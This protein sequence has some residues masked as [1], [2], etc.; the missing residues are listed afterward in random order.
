MNKNNGTDIF[1]IDDNLGG[2]TNEG[3]WRIGDGRNS[4]RYWQIFFE[5]MRKLKQI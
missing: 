4:Q 3:W 2:G 1:G 5:C